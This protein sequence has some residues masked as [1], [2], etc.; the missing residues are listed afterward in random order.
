MIQLDNLSMRF[1]ERTL[2]EGV[3][4]NL[5]DSCRYGITGAN[6]SGKSTLLGIL[7]EEIT[8]FGGAVRSPNALKVGFLK[9]DH[10][11]F[12]SERILDVVLMGRVRLWEALKEKSVLLEADLH[13]AKT[14]MRLAE[15]ESVISE[16]HGYSAESEAAIILDGLGIETAK[17]T[18]AMG[19]LSGGY[20]LRVLLAQ[21]LFSA[22]DLLLLDEPTNHLDIVSIAWLEK[23]LTD[24]DGIVVVVSHDHH[25][26]NAVVTHILDIDYEAVRLY[27]GNY[28][29]SLEAKGLN[30]LQQ[31][32]LIARQEKKKDELE[33]FYKRFRAQATKARQAMSRKKQLDK[34]DDVVIKRTSRIAPKFRF[35]QIRPSGKE[36]LKV[37]G[38]TKGFERK[39]PLVISDLS[40]NVMRGERVAIIGPNGAGKTT[41]MKLIV[42]ELTPDSG[43]VAGGHEV[44]IGYFAQN[45]REQIK[46]GITVYDWL[47]NHSNAETTTVVR[48]VLGAMLFSGD[49]ASKKS[50]AL[51]GGEA[52]RLVFSRLILAKDNLLLLDEP[53]NHLDIESIEAL[54]AALIDY[55]GTVIFVSHDRF[56]VEAVATS[57]LEITP[58]AFEYYKGS[59]RDF[60]ATRDA[61]ADH[62]NRANLKKER[63]KKSG[64][65]KTEPVRD[66]RALSKELSRATS[67]SEKLEKSIKEAEE[68]VEVINSE[69]ATGDLYAKGREVEL[70]K[71][72]EELKTSEKEAAS[73][74]EKWERA[75]KKIEELTE[76]VG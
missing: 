33:A 32:Q 58:G 3:S 47:L 21:C 44:Q 48:S 51:S 31:E 67:K 69:L 45:H 20:K 30:M 64:D 68:R 7:S 62:L 56:F 14:G 42:G 16:E 15:L 5:N 35:L 6:G 34:M 66:V 11:D 22:P 57:V 41:L 71:L 39:A 24:Y 63:V 74:M 29:F 8:D 46:P 72:L 54:A 9:Q 49:D 61:E 13:D 2:F 12:D 38:L 52:A 76:L 65:K 50:E 1:G 60:L 17:H 36:V 25:F 59:Y 10:F 43:E 19:T 55:P 27:H 75:H 40:M 37:K 53:T 4:L 23:Y 73:F 70:E 26:L 28:D 18:E